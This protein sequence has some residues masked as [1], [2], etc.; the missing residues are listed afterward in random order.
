MIEDRWKEPEELRRERPEESRGY[1]LRVNGPMQFISGGILLVWWF[2]LSYVVFFTG[3][4]VI[5]I[6]GFPLF[7]LATY[8]LARALGQ[9]F[10]SRFV[11]E[12]E[13]IVK[14]APFSSSKVY[15]MEDITQ[16]VWSKQRNGTEFRVYTG[17]T[18]AFSIYGTMTNCDRLI[19]E[20]RR[21]GVP[22]EQRLF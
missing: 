13:R 16:V 18:K 4:F 8:V 10:W 1:E 5:C 12:G 9:L 17:E 3:G 11:V 14:F 21:R 2:G 19:S 15:H 20:L 22:F 6:L 7:I